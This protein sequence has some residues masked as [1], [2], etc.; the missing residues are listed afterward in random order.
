L[1]NPREAE[2]YLLD[3]HIWE[4]VDDRERIFKILCGHHADFALQV[5]REVAQHRNK[6][7]VQLRSAGS[8]HE[9]NVVA[10][11]ECLTNTFW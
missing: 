5:L 9:L 10:S 4:V 2:T 11:F 7:H 8:A 6:F 1:A 3:G